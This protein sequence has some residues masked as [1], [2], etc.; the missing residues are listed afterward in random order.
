MAF[1]IEKTKETAFD[2]VEGM[3]TYIEQEK[4]NT[5][6]ISIGGLLREGAAFQGDVS[7]GKSDYALKFNLPGLDDVCRLLGL[8]SPM[9]ETLEKAGLALEVLNDRI[10]SK[11]LQEKLDRTQFVF[12]EPSKTVLGVVSESYVG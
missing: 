9:L 12:D 10:Y 3:M 1:N 2:C 5:S 11:S 8:Y 4:Q 6:R 7:F